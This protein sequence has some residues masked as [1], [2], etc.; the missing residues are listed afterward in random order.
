MSEVVDSHGHLETIVGPGWGF[1]GW[2]VDGG[3]AHE[4]GQRACRLEGLEVGDE[5]P[6]ALQR[7]ELQFHDG[8][9]IF[10]H[11]D[12]LGDLLAL[13]DVAAGHDDE[14]LA[15]LGK[16]GSAVESETG[17]C[18]GDD[19]ELAQTD[20]DSSEDLWGLLG[21]WEVVLVLQL[22]I[23]EDGGQLGAG[24]GGWCWGEG[25]R[26]CRLPLG[27]SIVGGQR[28]KGRRRCDERSECEEAHLWRSVRWVFA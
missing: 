15:G 24:L 21:L 26:R 4:M 17:G 13:L 12:V 28:G 11:A 25:G 19:H 27:D 14:V 2:L 18:S 20:L 3:V 8:V 10:W 9:G 23:L 16:S 1:V 22:G 5:I 7:S 6:D